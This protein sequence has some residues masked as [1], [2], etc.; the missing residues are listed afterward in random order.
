M[1]LRR[2]SRSLCR[3]LF[4]SFIV[5]GNLILGWDDLALTA[6]LWLAGM[7]GAWA[8][9]SYRGS[10]QSPASHH[11]KSAEEEQGGGPYKPNT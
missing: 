8:G 3:V 10:S 2:L 11:Q 5:L 1:K 9:W 6:I 4:A 7:A